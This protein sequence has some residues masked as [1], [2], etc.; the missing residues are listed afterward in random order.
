MTL[1]ILGTI[2]LLDYDDQL[3]LL[4]DQLMLLKKDQ[5]EPNERIVILHKDVEYFYYNS[6]TGFTTHNFFT[7]VRLLDFPLYVF[8]FLTNFSKYDQAILPFITDQRDRPTVY[9]TLVNNASYNN[10]KPLI[11]QPYHKE[12]KFHAVCLL[13][14][15]RSHRTKLFQFLKLNK[16][17]NIKYSFNDK[18]SKFL[19]NT[20]L[21]DNR[22]TTLNNTLYSVPHR[23]N[24]GWCQFVSNK[25]FSELDKIKI[26]PCSSPYI[27]ANNFEFYSDFAID[28]VVETMFDC[29]HVFISE[30]TLRPILLNTPFIMFGPCGTLEYLKTFGIQTFSSIWDESYD[31]I[32]DP[33][34][35][36]LA[37]CKLV[38]EINQMELKEIKE[39]YKK[40]IPI[41]E[42]N[43]AILINYIDTV[44]KP[45]Y[46]NRYV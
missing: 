46:N 36:F 7:L 24:D 30:K 10:I 6:L 13:G 25:K 45:L 43:R 27:N 11:D 44:F 17:D 39:L 14:T 8:I 5:F 33:V 2:D 9:N 42:H 1:N 29:P 3:E 40:I 12:I 41:V 21:A 23:V 38:E 15:V 22:S 18:K 32:E 19:S 34:D 37:C 16:I 4:H 20:S 35:R 28:V 31:L 26:E